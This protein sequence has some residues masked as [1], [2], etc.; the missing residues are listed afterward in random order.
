MD[1]CGPFVGARLRAIQDVKIACK[2]AP[3]PRPLK[4]LFNLTWHETGLVPTSFEL[5][6]FR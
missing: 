1:E 4:L 6:T 3:A 2:Q 5:W